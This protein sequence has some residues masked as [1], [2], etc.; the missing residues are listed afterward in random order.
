M[1]IN[2]ILIFCI[3]FIYIWIYS[4]LDLRSLL[5]EISVTNKPFP[6]RDSSNFESSWVIKNCVN[7]INKKSHNDKNIIIKLKN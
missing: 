7:C 4:I 2:A 1:F 5:R 3:K 6:L